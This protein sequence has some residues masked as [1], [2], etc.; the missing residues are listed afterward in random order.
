MVELSETSETITMDVRR[1]FY[2]GNFQGRDN[3]FKSVDTWTNS[4]A[5]NR[6]KLL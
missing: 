4:G 1:N 5:E 2:R 3:L 6:T